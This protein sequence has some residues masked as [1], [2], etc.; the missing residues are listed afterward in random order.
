MFTVYTMPNCPDC[1]NS[2]DLLERKGFKKNEGY[3]EKVA[4]VDFGREELIELIGPVRTLPQILVKKEQDT[5][6]I[7]GFANL[8]K[9][10][11]GELPDMKQ[12]FLSEQPA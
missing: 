11:N 2:K 5:Y 3:F 6:L 1:K 8:I 7:G 12:V 9:Y 10:F 4:G